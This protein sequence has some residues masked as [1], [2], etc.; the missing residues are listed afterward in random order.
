MANVHH[1]ERK[2]TRIASGAFR[3]IPLITDNLKA[4]ADLCRHYGMVKLEVFGSATTDAFDPETSDLDFIVDL[5][6]YDND[7]AWRFLDFAEA[8]ELLLGY[9][10]DLL[11]E[12]NIK[13]PYFREAVDE[14]RVPVW[15]TPAGA[16]A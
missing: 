10:V 16:G 8:L 12:A 4:I 15:S 6:G 7:V 1:N 13:N 2:H 9:E 14:Q 3:M 11:T 5:G